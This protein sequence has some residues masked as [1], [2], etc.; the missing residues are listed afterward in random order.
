[1]RPEDE[2]TLVFTGTGT[3][4][5]GKLSDPDH[6]PHRAFGTVK[7]EVAGACKACA[8][9]FG[10]TEQVEAGGVPPLAEY[11]GHQSLRRLVN[12]GYQVITF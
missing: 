9:S 6:R 2:V 12:E 5:V 11:R 4:R 7:D 8:V 1:M 10:M 3:K